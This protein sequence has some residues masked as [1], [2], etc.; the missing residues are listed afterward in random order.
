MDNTTSV[1]HSHPRW[2]MFRQRLLHTIKT[3][4][5]SLG[6]PSFF[7]KLKTTWHQSEIWRAGKLWINIFICKKAKNRWSRWLEM[8]NARSCQTP[9]PFSTSFSLLLSLLPACGASS[10]SDWTCHKS[11]VIPPIQVTC[12]L[13]VHVQERVCVCLWGCG[14]DWIIHE[15]CLFLLLYSLSFATF[16]RWTPLGFRPPFPLPDPASGH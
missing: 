2:L 12:P 15:A 5:H 8:C 13:C 16:H 10:G 9:C 4:T 14:L 3:I 11:T 1:K 6:P 7:L